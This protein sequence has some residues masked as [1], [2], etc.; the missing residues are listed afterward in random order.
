[1]LVNK[2][3]NDLWEIEGIAPILKFEDFI[4][5]A[6]YV[7]SNSNK[8]TGPM[9]TQLIGLLLPQEEFVINV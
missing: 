3:T 6:Y 4:F 9:I 2:I 8:R 7:D 5:T 1:M